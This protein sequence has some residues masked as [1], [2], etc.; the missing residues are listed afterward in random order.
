MADSVSPEAKKSLRWIG[1]DVRDDKTRLY[2]TGEDLGRSDLTF[3]LAGLGCFIEVK[4]GDTSWMTRSKD[5]RKG[6]TQ[7]QRSWAHQKVSALRPTPVWLWIS[8]GPDRPHYNPIKFM[9]RK[10]WLVPYQDV[11]RVV[12]LIEANGQNTLPYRVKARTRSFFKERNLS[13][14]T[15]FAGYELQWC[16]GKLWSIPE[17][18]KFYRKY[19]SA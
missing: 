9:P 13:C 6:W 5:P 16:G 3:I 10:T 18:H 12:E 1:G 8:V 7:Q 17:D 15:A 4:N 14:E 11:I 2:E 19:I